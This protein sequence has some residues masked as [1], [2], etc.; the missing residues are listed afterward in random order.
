MDVSDYYPL[1]P[2]LVAVAVILH[3]SSAF[4]PMI[5]YIGYGYF[6]VLT[7]VFITVRERISYLYEHPPIPAVYWEKNSWWSDI[8]LVLYL[9]PTVVLFLM[10]CFFWFKREKDLKGKTL[11]FLFFLVGM[12]LLFVYAFFFSMTLGYRP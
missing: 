7:V 5:K 9:M 2:L 6:F 8:G 10:V 12:I 3:R 4:A 1:I 11:T